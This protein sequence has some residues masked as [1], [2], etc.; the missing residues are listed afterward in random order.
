MNLALAAL[1]RWKTCNGFS[2]DSLLAAIDILYE[3]EMTRLKDLLAKRH[4]F[5]IDLISAY[6]RTRAYISRG[7]QNDS[8]EC[9]R[10]G[11]C[12]YYTPGRRCL[13]N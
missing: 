5:Q 8:M 3:T 6:L 9:Q 11:A 13:V 2:D 12:C 4:D 10:A 7:Q 1:K